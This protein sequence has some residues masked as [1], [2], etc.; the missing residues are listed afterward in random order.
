[1]LKHFIRY[2]LCLLDETIEINETE[3]S[4]P[5]QEQTDGS[6]DEE[7]QHTDSLSDDSRDNSIEL[8]KV[9]GHLMKK[10]QKMNL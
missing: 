2:K 10:W 1:L 3:I 9:E 8:F 5:L 4:K 7:Y 6:L